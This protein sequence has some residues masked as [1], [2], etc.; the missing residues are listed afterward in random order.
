MAG[1]RVFRPDKGQSVKISVPIGENTI[2]GMVLG[3]ILSGVTLTA[4]E[5]GARWFEQ[6]HIPDPMTPG[7][8]ERPH[9]Y[10]LWELPPG[11][12]EV[13]EQTVLVNSIGARGK[14]VGT[15]KAPNSRRIV[16]L[17]DNATF[18][19]GVELADTFAFDAVKSLG[20]SRVGLE[21]V[22]LAV[23][24]YTAMQHLNLMNMRGWDLNPDLVVIGGPSAEMA[25]QPYVDAEVIAATRAYSGPRAVLESFA[26]FRVMDRWANLYK[27]KSANTRRRVF[28]EGQNANVEG[29]PR[30][31]TNEYAQTLN[32]LVQDALDRSIDV[33]F[34]M[35]PVAEDLDDSHLSDTHFLYRQAMTAVA[36]RHGIPVIDGPTTF[37]D[38]RRSTGRLFL[39]QTL[40]SEA[41]HRT[42]GYALARRIKPWMRGRK[43]LLQGTGEPLPTLPEADLQPGQP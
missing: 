41:G 14:E 13:N 15:R 37:K 33:V 1:R 31:T 17:G 5:K 29:R 43:I 16:F 30:M 19:Q 32:Q 6:N 38:S 40:P 2:R 25:V 21:A 10:L 26:L 23:P 22:V 20:G 27:N 18:G 28:I 12:T 24:D 9:P 42:L 4:V 7:L 36:K 11:E 3:L 35:L 8:F 34:V 39:N